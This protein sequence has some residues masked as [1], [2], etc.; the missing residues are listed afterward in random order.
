MLVVSDA[1]PLNI[2]IRTGHIDV[3][4]NLFA[5]VAVP[6]SVAEEM[7]RSATPAIVREW[8][9]AAPS[10]IQIRTP[11]R[12]VEAR[13]LRHRGERDA[14]ALA[15]ELKADAILLDEEKPRKA[16][17]KEGLVVVGTVGVLERAA[18][19]GLVAD[20][21]AVHDQLRRTDFRIASVLLDQSYAQHAQFVRKT[22]LR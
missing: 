3:L 7:S 17:I 9:T 2:L 21:K 10:W 18:N 6:A 4:P 20:L 22:G 19:V 1:S 13:E 14:I 15:H 12:L 5:R 8:I 16:A 11:A